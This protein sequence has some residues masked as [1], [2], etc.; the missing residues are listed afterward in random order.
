MNIARDRFLNTDRRISLVI[1]DDHPI[2]RKGL[3]D[4]IASDPDLQILGEADNGTDAWDAI[5]T[6]V[7]D[8][9]VLDLAMPGMTGLEIAQEVHKSDLTTAVIILTVYDDEEICNKAIECG[10]H[11]YILKD[12][13]TIDILRCIHH[14]AEGDYYLSPTM[15]NSVLRK[16]Q[17]GD[18]LT[19]QRLGLNT[20]TP[21]E[22]HVL[23]L[24]AMNRSTREIADELSISPRTVDRHRYNLAGKLDLHGSF[25]LLRFALEH[26]KSL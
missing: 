11:G 7:P 6:L 8:V 5:R 3:H 25:A 18:A 15:T 21:V 9:A 4:I 24:I 12:C 13:T 10:V 22:R 26:S 1:A 2:V 20:L 16:N 19:E 14:V 17:Q 23:H